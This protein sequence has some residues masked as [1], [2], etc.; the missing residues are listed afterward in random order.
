MRPIPGVR[1]TV[2]CRDVHTP[3]SGML[4]GLI[5]G[6]YNY[7]E[8]HLDLQKL[9]RFA[10]AR[11]IHD[12]VTGVDLESKKLRFRDRPETGYDVLSIDIGSTPAKSEVPGA[13][14]FA[15][16]VKPIS[17]LVARWEALVAR[18]LA[19]KGEAR[20]GVVGAGAAG[21]ELTLA[22]EYRL[23]ELL[24]EAGHESAP[25]LF[26]FGAAPE[27]LPTHNRGVQRRFRRTLKERGVVC[28]LGR[29]VEEV[30]ASGLRTD[31]GAEY[32]LDEIL[33]T[34]QA[35][36]QSWP[37]EAG[38]KVD[39]RGFIKVEDTLESVSH[40]AVFAAGDVAAVLT[41]PREKAGV[42]AV[43]QGPPLTRNLRHALLGEPLEA[44]VPQ[45]EFLSLVSTGD[46]YAVGSRSFF[47]FEG[48]W[49]WT[50]KDYID[51]KFMRKFSD[52]LPEMKASDDDP[53]RDERESLMRCR[54]CGSKVGADVLSRVLRRL[55]PL[56][57][58]D[59]LIG[60]AA[61]EDAA[62]IR[63][64]EGKALVQTAD[65]FSAIVEDPYVFGKIAANH[66]L[67]DLFAMGAEPHSALAIAVTP[68]AVEAKTEETL[69]QLLAGA[70]EV[71]REAGAALIGGHSSEGERLALGF[72]LN[73]WAESDKLLRKG[74]A[75]PGDRLILTKA[76]G[77]GT[78]FAA[79]MARAAKGRW[80]A[81]AVEAMLTSNQAAANILRKCGVTALTDVTGFGLAGHLLEMLRASDAAAELEIDRVPTLPGA[82]ECAGAGHLSSLDAQN[83]LSASES[84]SGRRDLAAYPLLFDPQTSG[85][86]L[87]AT[88]A[89][90]AEACVAELRA[91]GYADASIVGGVKAAAEGERIELV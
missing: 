86:L 83:R 73:G 70:N 12:E 40:P 17:K 76:L 41:H 71:L 49:V 26:L 90:G 58:D 24:R 54:G 65:F 10:G 56:R 7:D 4:P 85:G 29:R 52:D 35:S 69:Y 22:I 63:P 77:T 89:E 67:S 45:K 46:R 23:R 51:R 8:A 21:A 5:A 57:R 64:P 82:I 32:V 25:E 31:D 78:L 38:L 18:V 66:A 68:F 87:A 53:L 79:E 91:A 88:P 16:A 11:F 33:W 72:T 62:A 60:L 80:V 59:V 9:A 39:G 50:W 1:L 28:V 19:A 13:D 43:R 55:E 81:A 74:G 14:R 20:I 75:R 47:T 37:G 84:V 61:A 3:Y 44:F 36:A 34:T 27:P 42:F 15:T 2:V 6:H 30:T 48:E